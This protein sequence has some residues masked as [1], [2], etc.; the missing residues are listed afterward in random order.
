MFTDFPGIPASG[1]EPA[2]AWRI[3]GARDIPFKDNPLPP[4][5]RVRYGHCRE[6]SFCIRVLRVVVKLMLA[7]K[8]HYFAEIHHSNPVADMLHHAKVMGDEKIGKSEVL[9]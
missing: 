4:L 2:P 3:Y 6:K 8:F 7:G 5:G 1:M 9:L